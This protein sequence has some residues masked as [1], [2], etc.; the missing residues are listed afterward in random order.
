LKRENNRER[1]VVV[2]VVVVVFVVV[3]VV[4]SDTNFN[5]SEY[6]TQLHTHSTLSLFDMKNFCC[7]CECE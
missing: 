4:A 1:V 3:V 6:N 7:C 5:M 2:V